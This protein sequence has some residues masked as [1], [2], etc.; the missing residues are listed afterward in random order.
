[1]HPQVRSEFTRD[2]GAA[3]AA[4]R[5]GVVD[6]RTRN[7]NSHWLLWVDFCAECSVDPW[8]HDG[9]DPIPYLQVFAARY[10][11]GRLAPRGQP[12]RSG[13][14][15]DALRS[16]GQAFQSVGARD[17]RLNPHGRLD[18]RLTRQLR[19]YSKQDPPPTRVKPVPIQVVQTMVHAAYMTPQQDAGFQAIADMACL[20]FFFLLRPG[21]HT[22]HRDNT[23][24]TV[25]DVRLFVG[26]RRLDLLSSSAAEMAAATNVQLVFT[27]QKNGVR[28]EII[29]HGRSGA[30]LVC[31]VAAVARRVCYLR[32]V[33]LPPTSPLCL[34]LDSDSNPRYVTSRL[35][36]EALRAAVTLLG[37]ANIDLQPHEIEA[38]S[39]RAGGATALLCANI[40]SNTIQLIGRWKS[41]AMLRYLHVSAL[42]VMNR[43]A[44]HMYS[45]GNYSFLPYAIHPPPVFPTLPP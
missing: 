18:F 23:P 38:R 5:A 39:L 32:G 3:Q 30:P 6:Q 17:I 28:G 36:T 1:M 10:R 24:F 35:L 7:A 33:G 16:V 26:N 25:S 4:V 37:P 20:G 42:P 29:A 44:S 41:D 31:P 45:G 22:F 43:Y 15:S 27:T 34:F 13:T 12:V 19:S 14:V 21:E 2:L 8:F 40:D 11:D 9:Q